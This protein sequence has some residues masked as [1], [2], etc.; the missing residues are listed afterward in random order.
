MN[1]PN[2]IV[3]GTIIGLGGVRSGVSSQGLTSC[4]V[5]LENGKELLIEFNPPVQTSI[6]RLLGRQAILA[7]DAV[8]GSVRFV[9]FSDEA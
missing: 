6:P 5:R 3:M 7:F 1:L 4:I 9:R 8:L 2:E